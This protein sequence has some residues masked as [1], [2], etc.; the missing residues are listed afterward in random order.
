MT[1]HTKENQSPGGP[2]PGEKVR[3]L[4]VDGYSL[5]HRAFFAL[6]EMRSAAGQ[7]T[8][9]VLGF[10]NMLL[11]LID[12]EGPTH[13][14]VAFDAPGP[15]FRH[16]S[17][18]KYK[19]TRPDTPDELRSQ[20]PLVREALEA[21]NIVVIERP[22]YEADD[23]IGALARDAKGDCAEVVMVT[24]D[25][26]LLQLVDEGV[27]ALLTRR[28][29]TDLKTYDVAR[30]REEFG[31]EPRQLIDVKG[32][33][34]DKSDNIPGV[35]GVGEKTALKLIHQYGD[36][37]N[38]LANLDDVAGKKLPLVLFEHADQARLSRVL[39]EIVTDVPLE[40][41]W[42]DCR[43]G[44]L[45][46]GRVHELFDS[47]GFRALLKRLGIDGQ[48]AAAEATRER[49]ADEQ[50]DIV[51]L[52]PG[53]DLSGLAAV[54][55]QADRVSWVY[56]FRA[57]QPDPRRDSL[58]V[59]AIAATQRGAGSEGVWLVECD[60][61]TESGVLGILAA[62]L[63]RVADGD[64]RLIV[65]D[66]KPL[67]CRYYR[68][69]LGAGGRMLLAGPPAGGAAAED[70]PDLGQIPLFDTA[71]AGY[72]LD[73]A[74][75]AY[76]LSDLFRQYS[77]LAASE[78]EDMIE[79]G[80][81][82]SGD[83]PP[84]FREISW[85]AVTSVLA[86]HAAAL[87]SL[88]D[89]MGTELAGQNLASLFSAIE[90]PLVEV[91]ARMEHR[92][93]RV[94]PAVLEALGKTFGGRMEELTADIYEAAG[95][96][97]NINSTQQ[98][99]EVLFEEMGLPAVKRT[100]TGYSTDAEVLEALAP[101]HPIA[102]R[103]LE[104]R[105]LSKLQGTYVEGLVEEIE[106]TDGRIHTTFQQMVAATGRLASTA[107]N[108]Q[109]IPIRDEPGRQLRRAFVAEPGYMLAAADYE[110]V[111]LRILAHLS[112]DEKLNEAFAGGEDIHRRTAAEVF[113]VEPQHVTDGQRS[114]AKAVNFGIIYG[115]S[116]FGLARQLGITREE[117]RKYIKAYLDR[118]PRVDSFIKETVQKAHEAGHVRTL[119]DRIRHLPELYSRIHHRR[120]FAERTA[121]N[122]PIQ[123]SAADIIKLAMVQVERRLSAEGLSARL[124]LQIHDELI[125]EAP[126][127]EIPAVAE[128]LSAEMSS[129]VQLTVP[130][131]VEVKTGANWYDMKVY[132]A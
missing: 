65:H 13:L 66:L 78:P 124:L 55:Q 128:L 4:L 54:V 77:G 35:P 108:L 18:R 132:D 96:S 2:G 17:F 115:I 76:R 9:A 47:L 15:T 19:A 70:Q 111:E 12:D 27:S 71:V 14:A 92:G 107:P 33:M 130:L 21:M 46:Q 23:I 106:A 112:G 117:A 16:K 56:R 43:R 53:D 88:S 87:I 79:G 116:D 123:G 81:R 126:E 99:A 25:R 129:C 39:A 72:V 11:R 114:A 34:G 20:F 100:K 52:G 48:V 94:D 98:L 119:Y 5:I 73:P 30:V 74:R 3:L 29:I 95:H 63:R 36:I 7:P 93:V 10:L 109:N 59:V 41:R 57:H 83:E 113:G 97:F 89:A 26:D 38:V 68:A 84:L 91:L 110:Q 62:V 28:G 64:A 50:V 75:T 45:N 58:G 80:R 104:Y 125:V 118:Y 8:H 121:M 86:E 120:Q 103:L 51:R 69:G 31:I 49:L 6:P 37:E 101:Q 1:E 127:K 85:S 42:Q 82:R 67:L 44:D 32:L 60:H 40:I 105:Q 131:L 102:E 122:T 22:G 24:G 90:M 61:D